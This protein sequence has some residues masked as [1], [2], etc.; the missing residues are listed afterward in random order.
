MKVYQ[1]VKGQ[2]PFTFID[3]SIRIVLISFTLTL[4]YSE[5]P[6]LHI[7]FNPI[8]LRTTKTLWSFGCSECNRVIVISDEKLDNRTSN[9]ALF[10]M[11]I[12]AS[13]KQSKTKLSF[14]Y[15]HAFISK[16]RQPS[17]QYFSFT[18]I[19]PLQN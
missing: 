8:A 1:Y 17:S 3:L 2:P 12:P 18:Y 10:T 6:K 16:A 14:P 15:L 11:S 7:Y 19:L 13:Q 5:R 9:S 4:L